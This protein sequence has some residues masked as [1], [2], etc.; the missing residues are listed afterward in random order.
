M[1]LFKMSIIILIVLIGCDVFDNNDDKILNFLESKYDSDFSSR[2]SDTPL[3]EV[4]DKYTD[5][6]NTTIYELLEKEKEVKSLF[7]R[8]GVFDRYH[9]VELITYYWHQSLNLKPFDLEKYLETR[10]AEENLR[11]KKREKNKKI[12]ESNYLRFEVG[13]TLVV[14][15]PV[16]EL[17]NGYRRASRYEEPISWDF[18]ENKDLAVKCR[19]IKKN[20]FYETDNS[21]SFDVIVLNVNRSDT[22]LFT[23]YLKPNDS[24]TV[25]LMLHPSTI[26]KYRSSR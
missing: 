16:S 4:M 24:L 11:R 13:D 5:T 1:R 10:D 25:N 22:Y 7:E 21:Y 12:S 23:K 9:Q 26:I 6:L 17:E 18:D 19:L 15:Y 20:I 14:R 3:K 8:Y 2:F